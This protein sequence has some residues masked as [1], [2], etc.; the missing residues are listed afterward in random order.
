MTNHKV[1]TNNPQ[2]EG[3]KT[4]KITTTT[5]SDMFI[6]TYNEN[7]TKQDISKHD[8][9]KKSYVF[10]RKVIEVKIKSE[11]TKQMKNNENKKVITEEKAIE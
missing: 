7:E 4:E 6:K 2:I 10:W 3:T 5:N 9:E 1:S 8:S 11:E